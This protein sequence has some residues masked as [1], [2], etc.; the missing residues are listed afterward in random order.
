MVKLC[1]TNSMR[2]RF[3]KK[4]LQKTKI[5]S[6]G[7]LLITLLTAIFGLISYITTNVYSDT[8]ENSHTN[9]SSISNTS[10]S[11]NNNRRKGNAPMAANSNNVVSNSSNS[12][13]ISNTINSN[14]SIVSKTDVI[15]ISNTSSAKLGVYTGP[16]AISAHTQFEQWLGRPVPYAEDYIDFKGGW[17]KDFIDSQQWLMQPWGNWVK[18]DP[19]RRLVLGVPMLESD[20]AGQFSQGASGQFDIYF[21]ALANELVENGLG[22]TIIRLGYE[23]NCDTIGPWQATDNPEGYIMLYR[24]IVGVMKAVPDNS[25]TFDWSVCNGLQAGHVLNSFDSFYPGDDVVDIIS[26]DLYDVAW[27]QPSITPQERWNYIS[28]RVM[29]I[30]DLV[31]FALS[32]DKPLS[33]PEWGLYKPGDSFAGGG[34][35]PYFIQQMAQL[36]NS[37]NPVYQAYFDID[38]GGGVLSDFLE[39]AATYQAI[40]GN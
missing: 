17:Q 22:N 6:V 3:Y 1:H 33:F 15:Q 14:A 40:Y 34:D 23:G 7:I 24:H 13:H 19:T 35:D 10:P 37:T 28:T 18:Q 38:W 36:I 39:G 16:G 2:K 12:S 4:T 8:P 26:M 21:T 27:M 29:G 11:S 5:T 32:H 20:N 25:F 31:Q 9:S 30:N